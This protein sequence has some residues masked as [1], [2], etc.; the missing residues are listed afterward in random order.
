MT[1]QAKRCRKFT[2][3]IAKKDALNASCDRELLA[4][5]ENSQ[6][7]CSAR[8]V[9]IRIFGIRQGLDSAIFRLDRITARLGIGTSGKFLLCAIQKGLRGTQGVRRRLSCTRLPGNSNSLPRIAHLLYRRS[10]STTSQCN[11]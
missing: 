3:A 7:D 4:H 6:P 10:G 5:C 1:I 11:E 2:G 9:L 8:L